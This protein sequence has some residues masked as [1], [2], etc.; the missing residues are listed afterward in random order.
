MMKSRISPLSSVS[1]RRKTQL[2]SAR[3]FELAR[4]PSMRRNQRRGGQALLLAVV[5]MLL[6][7]LLSAGFLAVLS[8]N[9]NQTA[10]ISDKSRAIEASR[11]GVAYA[12]QQLTYSALGDQWRPIDANPAPVPTDPGYD[13]YYSQLDK[14]Q[15]WANQLAFPNT[16]SPTYQQDLKNYRD[17]VYAKFPDPNQPIGNAPK[18]LVK[19]EDLPTNPG[20]AFYTVYNHPYDAEHAGEIRITSVGLSDDD[21]NVFNKTV[22][23]KAGSQQKP[24]AV[25]LRSI[26][27]WEFKTNRVPN[28]TATADSTVAGASTM[29]NLS[30]PPASITAFLNKANDNNKAVFAVQHRHRRAG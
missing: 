18:F 15:G 28:G 19:V 13:L 23:Y 1:P 4:V 20:D 9:L 17:T 30:G 22:A 5:I 24:W 26:S 29:V 12:N 27:N 7:A 16:A 21:P 11:T 3:R 10:R 14:V 8:G 25:A 2:S 6:A